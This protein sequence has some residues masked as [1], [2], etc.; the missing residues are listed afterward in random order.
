MISFIFELLSFV[1]NV[2][3]YLRDYILLNLPFFILLI[4][5][6]I[7]F[8][9]TCR[10]YMV[11]K[12]FDFG[13]VKFLGIDEIFIYFIS[14]VNGTFKF[15]TAVVLEID[16]DL[17]FD[18]DKLILYWSYLFLSH[19][20]FTKLNLIDLCK[21]LTVLQKMQAQKMHDARQFSERNYCKKLDNCLIL[22]II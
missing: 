2:S 7:I 9:F 14:F 22:L 10:M 5:L 15:R 16:L 19:F 8:L 17:V 1:R 12:V 13:G 18:L 20:Q 3:H 4:A 6:P 21:V 11:E